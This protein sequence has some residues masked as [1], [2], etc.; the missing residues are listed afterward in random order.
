M[1]YQPSEFWE[2]KLKNHF[3]LK[4]VGHTHLSEKYNEY[5]YNLK[6]K[7][8]EKMMRKNKIS[9]KDKTVL[10][11]GSGIGFFIN[12]YLKKQAKK[13]VGVDI[14]K[15]SIQGLNNRFIH[16]NCS[17]KNADIGERYISINENFDLVNV[18]DVLYHIIDDRLF[19]TALNNIKDFL[20]KGGTVFITDIFGRKDYFPAKDVHFRS[21]QKYQK[22]L[23]RKEI[24]IVDI[25]PMYYLMN[26]NF[27]LPPPVL[28]KASFFL[29]GTDN[30]FQHMGIRNGKNM[31]LL[32][33]K[34]CT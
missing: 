24:E 12:Y 26:R 14:T 11:I 21:L 2:D 13:V 34:N 29:H 6:V 8:L 16:Q 9:V 3:N 19:E 28:N 25:S 30:F 10:D 5:L 23:G 20:K 1:S 7:A 18:F 27:N 32:V 17:F 31:K 4:G 15:K 22:E 33:G